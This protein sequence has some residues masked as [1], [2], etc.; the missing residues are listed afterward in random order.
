MMLV[1]KMGIIKSYLHVSVNLMRDLGM[2][3]FYVK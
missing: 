2:G 3:G 1:L